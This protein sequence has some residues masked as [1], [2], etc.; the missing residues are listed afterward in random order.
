MNVQNNKREKSSDDE[1]KSK[2]KDKK[3]KGIKKIYWFICTFIGINNHILLYFWLSLY[4]DAKNEFGF[5]NNVAG[6]SYYFSKP[7]SRTRIRSEFITVFSLCATVIT[8]LFLNDSFIALYITD[9]VFTSM[10]AVASSTRTILAGFNIALAIL[11]S[12]L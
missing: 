3:T 12:C 8:V 5:F 9:S 7:P 10:F 11:M 6:E 1:G 4:S 2:I